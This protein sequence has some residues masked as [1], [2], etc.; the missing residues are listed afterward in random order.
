[1]LITCFVERSP[2]ATA[3]VREK[4]AT[5]YADYRGRGVVSRDWCS[6]LG[7]T[8]I[9]MDVTMYQRSPASTVDSDKVHNLR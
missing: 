9:H 5:R 2:G 7:Q 4:R 6:E 8:H 3:V 1:M